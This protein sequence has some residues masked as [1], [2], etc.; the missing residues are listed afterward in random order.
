MLWKSHLV[1]SYSGWKL[2]IDNGS[3]KIDED[4]IPK[5]FKEQEE[6]TQAWY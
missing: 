5:T 4:L 3:L 2:L 6:N 1:F